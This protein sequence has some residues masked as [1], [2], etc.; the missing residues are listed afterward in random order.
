MRKI[1][2]AISLLLA[3]NVSAQLTTYTYNRKLGKVI[4]ESFYSIP[5]SPEITARSK[6]GLNDM[7]IYN[8]SGTD[9]LEI[10]YLTE[11]MGDKTEDLPI[12][13]ELINDV[14]NLKCC[15]YVTLK[16]NERKVINTINLDVVESNFDKILTIEGSND[17]KEWF[18]IKDHLRIV[19]FDNDVVDFRSTSISFPSAEYNYFRIKFDDDGSPKI[20]VNNASAFE[21]RITKGHYDQLAVKGQIQTENK[22]EKTSDLIIDL[23][24]NNMLSYVILKSGSQDDF[25]RNINIYSSTGIYHT[26]KGDVEG[27]RMVNSGV[28]ISSVDNY[29]PLGNIQTNRL[30]VEVINYDNQPITLNEVKVYSEKIALVTKL[31][32]SDQLYLAYGKENDIAPVYDLVHFKD[33][34]PAALDVL[35]LGKEELK[36]KTTLNA[37][38]EPLVKNKMWLWLVMGVVIL[39][40]G[41][42]AFSMIRKEK[43]E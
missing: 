20:T 35:S 34:I 19:G 18:M 31:P 5:L 39:L 8:I 4:K 15:S 36:I 9:T 38:S 24:D 10:P 25:Y 6:S 2:L 14:T 16:M 32:V 40:I 29:F 27:W 17:N 7:R 23:Q 28:I 21:S 13:F 33:K 1:F 30:K 11:W 22:K 41:Y 42:F 43:G 37:S 3:F 26:P 12:T